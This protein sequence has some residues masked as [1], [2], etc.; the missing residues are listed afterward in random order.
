MMANQIVLQGTVT[1]NR[2]LELAGPVGLPPGPVEV[3]LTSQPTRPAERASN[4]W[5]VLQ[6]IRADREA[7]GYPFMS[8]AEVTADVAELRADDDR[9][10]R[11]ARPSA[12]GGRPE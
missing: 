5:T 12:P 8:E 9:P 3:K 2:T 1:P 10:E 6:E 11:L 4:W 7:R